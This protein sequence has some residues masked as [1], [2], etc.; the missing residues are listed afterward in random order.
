MKG[1][2]TKKNTGTEKSR[3]ARK[4]SSKLGYLGILG[5]MGFLGFW[6]YDLNKTIFPFCFFMFFGFFGFF[7]E[8]KMSNTYMDERYNENKKRAQFLSYKF[9]F[10]SVF[11]LI[12]MFAVISSHVENLDYLLISLVIAISLFLSEYFL[13]H[14]DQGDTDDKTIDNE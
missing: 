4:I 12:V 1:W 2:L 7:Y 14:F 8:G 5:L 11:V 9:G 3:Y 13:Y 6:T 10:T